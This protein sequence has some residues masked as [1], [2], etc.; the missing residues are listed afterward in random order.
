MSEANHDSVSA[1]ANHDA[2]SEA[3]PDVV[4]DGQAD[5]DSG[6]SAA[7]RVVKGNPDDEDVAALVAVLTAAPNDSASS[8]DSRPR[9]LWGAPSS[10]H[11]GFAAQSAY[12]YAAS[13]R[14]SR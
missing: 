6:M 9:E 8:A 12:S 7:I 2:V 1:E 5:A 13:G 14:Y 10:M 3:S 11:R 4:N